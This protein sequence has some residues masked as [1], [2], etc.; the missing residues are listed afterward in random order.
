LKV[1][2]GPNV[3]QADFRKLCAQAAR[4]GRDAEVEKISASF[5]KRIASIEA[6][7]VRE[8]RELDQDETELSQRKLEEMGTHAENVLSLFSRRR[9]TLTTS[10]TK[11]RLTENAKADVKE[12]LQAI[13][14]FKEELA[15][16]EKEKEQAVQEAS[17]R[18]EEIAS[19]STEIPVA[20]AKKDILLDLFGVAWMPYYVVQIGEE[21]VELPGYRYDTQ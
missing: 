11:R 6:K 13:E 10:L 21:V 14:V 20:P 3:S 7:L 2:A 4:A 8:Q 1:F 5:D 15:A 18:W 12:S 17:D 19:H 9:R 16:L